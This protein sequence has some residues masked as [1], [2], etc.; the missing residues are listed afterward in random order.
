M[1]A[2]LD[3]AGVGASAVGGIHDCG[4]G[5]A[6][7]LGDTLQDCCPGRCILRA[8]GARVRG[9]GPKFFHPHNGLPYE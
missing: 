9:C 4:G 8:R 7:P 1:A 2:D 6:H 3:A 5:P